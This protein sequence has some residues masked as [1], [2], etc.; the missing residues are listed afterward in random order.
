MKEIL[1]KLIR[2]EDLNETD[3]EDIVSN[4]EQNTFVPNQLAGILCALETKKP[5]PNEITYFVEKL[6]K[7]AETINLGEDCIDVCGT[8]GDEKNTFN[9]STATMFVAAGAGA[10]LAKH[11]N[12]AVSSN[13]GSFDVLE[14]LGVN[15][16]NLTKD[17]KKVM[18]K[19]GIAFL[20]AQKHHPIFKNIGPLRKELGVKTIFN[21]LGPLLNPSRVKK[22]LM[23]VFNSELT[24]T[25]AEVMK[26]TGVQRA[27]VVNG[28]GLDEITITGKTKITQLNEGKITTTYFDP[29]EYGFNYAKIEE[30]R[31]NT[32]EES[33]KIILSVLKG[34]KSAKRNVVVLNAAAAL[35]VSGKT[36][37]FKEGIKLAE[38]SIDSG[39]AL[40]KLEELKLITNEEAKV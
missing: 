31:A 15:T 28:E 11:G 7:K 37:D 40:K 13:S 14:A 27:M 18:K 5:T 6:I 16:L 34:E 36:M 30:L 2:K 1:K 17:P 26:K 33:A 20:F 25:V 38:K 3:V 19:T 29:K 35:I 4:I 22:Q 21:L 39:A 23:G 24:E 32:K 8:G 10:K 9:I 12:K